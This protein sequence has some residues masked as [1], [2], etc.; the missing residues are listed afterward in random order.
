MFG[1]LSLSCAMELVPSAYHDSTIL[2]NI[3]AE[4]ISFAFHAQLQ[5]VGPTLP[6]KEFGPS[7]SSLFLFPIV[8]M[9]FPLYILKI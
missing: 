4:K 2:A 6:K 1:L 3:V 5:Y 7:Y 8:C 9:L